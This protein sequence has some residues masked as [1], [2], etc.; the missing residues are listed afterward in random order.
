M[1]IVI[2]FTCAFVYTEKAIVPI[3]R[4]KTK[5]NFPAVIKTTFF[6]FQTRS[7]YLCKEGYPCKVQFNRYSI[8]Y[9]AY[10]S[11]VLPPPPGWASDSSDRD[12]TP[13]YKV[14]THILTYNEKI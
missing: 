5:W 13:V 6:L 7:P 10:L 1:A 14:A 11:R 8:L 9:T 4:I 2:N 3:I 12:S